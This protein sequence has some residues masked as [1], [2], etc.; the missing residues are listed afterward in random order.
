MDTKR[1]Q[2]DAM[3]NFLEF[4]KSQIATMVE[5]VRMKLTKNQRKLMSSLIIVDVH[6]RDVIE[7]ICRQYPSLVN[8]CTIDWFDPWPEEALFTVAIK[9]L[10][11]N[12]ALRL[13]NFET[14]IA[15]MCVEIHSSVEKMSKRFFEELRRY[16]YTTPT[17]YLELIKLYMHM[18]MEQKK[19]LKDQVSK[20][21]NGLQK[22]RETNI[23][24][25]ELKERLIQMQPRLKQKSEETQN[26]M[27]TLKV[28]QKEAAEKERLVICAHCAMRAY[29][30]RLRTT[31]DTGIWT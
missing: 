14:C 3:A 25:K 18:L 1:G 6:A 8:C 4:S 16:N 31:T 22:L 29:H 20:Y 27:K 26:L 11:G 21:Q 17:S 10:S 5:R 13:G 9:F 28:D 2:K 12:E 15:K 19:M 7:D 30:I 24:V 23:I